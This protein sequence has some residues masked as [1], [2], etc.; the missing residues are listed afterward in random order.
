MRNSLILRLIRRTRAIIEEDGLLALG[1]RVLGETVYRRA[2][3]AR[4][5]TAVADF[6]PDGRCRWL[7]PSEAAA[8][9]QFHLDVTEAEVRRRLAEG[10]RCW[11][12]ISGGQFAHGLWVGPRA[13]INY[14][15]LELPLA[16]NEIYLYQ[17]FTPPALRGCG[18][19]TAALR[20]VLSALHPEG[21]KRIVLC[22]QPDRSIAYPPLYR[23]GFQPFGYL[24]WY[25]LGPMR[26]TFRRTANR[27]PFY[28]PPG[29]PAAGS[30]Q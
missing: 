6:P 29:A 23:A 2:L 5:G 26:W 10:H 17:T 22:I 8:Y 13:W 20:A 9:A 24:G 19:A 3:L 27:F 14:L 7:D 12:L 1:F 18:Y 4:C 30:D 28:A 16:P 15:D 21:W 11:V 25:R